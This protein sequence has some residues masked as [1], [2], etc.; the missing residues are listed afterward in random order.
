MRGRRL[1]LF[2]CFATGVWAAGQAPKGAC[3]VCHKLRTPEL[4][5]AWLGSAHARHNVTCLDCHEASPGEADA[6]VHGGATV[7]VLVTP[8]DCA[9]CHEVEATQY[10]RSPHAASAVDPARPGSWGD[11]ASCRDCHGGVALGDPASRNRLKPTAWPDRGTGRQNPDGSRGSCSACH[12]D[13]GFSTTAART[14]KTCTGC[15]SKGHQPHHQGNT[16]DGG[17]AL[18]PGE[19]R[20]CAQCHLLTGGKG[21]VVHDPVNR[22]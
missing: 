10:G 3:L 15:H 20:N 17:P 9:G 1:L 11:P 5:Q 18:K 8:K 6:F 7:S 13:H 21:G 19:A 12:A 16:Q 22:R 14:D 2:L 4:Y